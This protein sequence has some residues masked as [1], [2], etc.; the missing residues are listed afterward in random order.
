MPN[1]DELTAYK[2]ETM[3][4]M[5]AWALHWAS[6]GWPVLP[7]SP[8]DKSP[9]TERGKHDASRDPVRIRDWWSRFPNAM[10]GGRTDG[11]AV[12]D[13]DAYKA[14]H[15]DDLVNLSCPP[16]RKF[17][18]PGRGGICGS[19]LVYL[20]PDGRIR[21]GKLG[22]NRTVDIR[23]GSSLD[24][25]ILPPSRNSH[26][27]AYRVLDWRPAVPAPAWLLEAV[28]GHSVTAETLL[29]GLPPR[30]PLPR[31]LSVVVP[32]SA[33]PSEHTYL[34]ARNG[35][36]ACLTPG[37]I[38]TLLEDDEVT[39]E[40]LQAARRQQ[41]GWWPDE[42][43]RIIQ[44]AQDEIT[45]A[46]AQ[47]DEKAGMSQI[48]LQIARRDF[49]FG[50]TTE[51]LPFA[52][53]KTG[54][55]LA[56][57]FRGGKTSFRAKLAARFEQQMGRPPSNSALYE[58]LETLEGNTS[59][60][61]MQHLPLR[62]ARFNGELVLDLGN[63][64]GR[65]VVIGP[66][67][68]KVVEQSPVLFTRTGLTAPLPEPVR[69]GKLRDTILPMLNLSGPDRDLVI[70]CVLSWLWPDIAHPVIYLR[71]EEG[72]AKSTAARLLRRLV[73]PS[74]VEM[75]RQPGRDE[76]FEVT[77]SGQWG[78]VL[79]N[80]SSISE[81]LSDAICTAVTGVGDIKRKKYADQELSVLQF[82][83]CFILT[84]IPP[85]MDRGDL[86]DRTCAF[87]LMPVG[88]R[89][90]DTEIEA[91]WEHTWPLALGAL[92]DLACRVLSLMPEMSAE[93]RHRDFRM[94]DFALIA[95]AMD[96]AAGTRAL[97]RLAEKVADGVRSAVEADPFAAHLMR[98]AADGWSGSAHSLFDTYK[99]RL[100]LA[101]SDLWPKNPIAMSMR[102]QRMAGI[103]RKS[104]VVAEKT[105][106]EKSRGWHLYR[107]D[108]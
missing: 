107:A 24:Y 17:S 58:A 85:L 95:A 54:P 38:R 93:G 46:V 108:T 28:P 100:R 36:R 91:E 53:P 75:R 7:C 86:V 52:V 80:L 103:L 19:H 9:L 82:R 105:R 67:V 32:A 48:V 35:L 102:I 25:I 45:G 15:A 84:S 5:L 34:L 37:Q 76:D 66:G 16:T 70:A 57:V 11:L 89:R 98:L 23:A 43:W 27:E 44:R 64:D 51:S 47:P 30:E 12:L 21:S 40:R 56:Q 72:T 33:D 92:L 22:R 73:D 96:R 69:G 62:V 13:L 3:P 97:P 65:V 50:Q 61:P 59:D 29:E 2:L 14:G 79:D 31:S 83:R 94:A 99:V 78:I 10:I 49:D 68:W 88:A 81:W 106:T 1:L 42:F 101:G 8:E 63:P 90:T 104:G 55:R 4:R 20:D 60:L 26:G 87:D 41:P 6:L 71:G 74:T 77:L 18:T 39:R